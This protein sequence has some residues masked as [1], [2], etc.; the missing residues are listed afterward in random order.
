M[1]ELKNLSAGYNGIDVVRDIS[2]KLDA[3]LNLCIVGPNGCGKTTLL[4]AIAGIIPIKG[5]VLIDGKSIKSMKRFQIAKKI[6]VMSQMSA[7]YFS[8][9]VFETVLLGRYLYM[10]DKILKEPSVNDISYVEECLE[11]VGMLEHRDKQINTLSGGQ[12]QR[13]FLARSLAQEPDIILLDEPTNH[14]DLKSQK[15][16]IVYLKKWTIDHKHSLIGVF[17][18]L[19][20]AME[21]GDYLLVLE[22]GNAKALGKPEDIIKSHL[23]NEVYE[24]DIAGYM[25]NSLKRCEAIACLE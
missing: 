3:G 4:K 24:M 22:K 11:T 10:K 16:L 23:L 19:N 14:L 21:V 20:H 25:V 18:D 2:F 6:A 12:L 17:H 1:I 8:Y 7:I 5:D 9:T 13:V 15:E